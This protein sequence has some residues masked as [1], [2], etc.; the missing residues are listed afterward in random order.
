LILIDRET[1]DTVAMGLI[2][3]GTP[4]EAEVSGAPPAGDGEQP[5]PPAPPLRWISAT[6]DRPWRSL[7]KAVSWRVTGSIDTTI[8]AFIFT[9][10][11]KVAAAI[12]G[13]EVFTKIVLYFIHERIWS[14]LAFG[15]SPEAKEALRLRRLAQK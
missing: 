9:G 15:L 10:N 14:R 7:A 5:E 13:T 1:Y 8:L 3:D 2:N 11:I 4:A 12:G 6:S